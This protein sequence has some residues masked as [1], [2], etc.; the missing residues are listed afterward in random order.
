MRLKAGNQ[1]FSM[2]ILFF[3]FS[4]LSIFQSAQAQDQAYK[5]SLVG[6]YNLENLFDTLDT[7]NVR[8]TEFTP[9]GAKL[10]GTRVYN[11]KL[12]NLARVVSEIGTD[13]SPDGLAILGV[14]EVENRSVLEDFVA[15][16]LLADR[17]YEI[18]HYDSPDERGID[19]GLLYNPKY[20]EL[21]GSKAYPL[22]LYSS[23]GEPD[24]TR[25]VLLVSGQFDGEPM[26]F[27][28]N[29]WP[30]RSGGE[31]NSQDKRAAAALLCKSIADSLYQADP[32]SKVI[33][34]G[35]LNDDPVSPSVRK[36]LNT[37]GKENQVRAGGLYNPMFRPFKQ[38]NGTLA[39]NGAWN[40]FDQI[41]IS[42]SM[43]NKEQDGFFYHQAQIFRAPYLFQRTGRYKGFPHRTFSGDL[44]IGGYSDHLPVFI[45]LLKPL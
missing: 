17:N 21:Q 27:L 4:C 5:I 13:L 6:F 43:L 22:K 11:E 1:F 3:V 12:G 39:Y 18:V 7:P 38:G 24:Y 34:M 30:S 32:N 44:Y 42:G 29:H 20:F 36:V 10:Y 9:D 33:I 15:H 14:A 25:D 26:H 35:D 16:P 2:R 8:D 40:L 31:A 41:I 37:K 23:D 45:V 28:V 19:V